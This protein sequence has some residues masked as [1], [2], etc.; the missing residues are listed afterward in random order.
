MKALEIST[1]LWIELC[2]SSPK[3]VGILSLRTAECGLIGRQ[4][5]EQK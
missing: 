4:G 1:A 5:L 3:Y 2:P